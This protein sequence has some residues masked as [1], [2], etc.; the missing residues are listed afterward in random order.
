MSVAKLQV[1]LAQALNM[2]LVNMGGSSTMGGLDLFHNTCD[3]SPK[4]MEEG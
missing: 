1:L 2:H 3:W 4:Q